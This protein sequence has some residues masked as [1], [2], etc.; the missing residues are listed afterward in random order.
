[1]R[2]IKGK[3]EGINTFLLS[4]FTFRIILAAMPLSLLDSSVISK[5]NKMKISRQLN[6]TKRLGMTGSLLP[7]WFLF[8]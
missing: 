7:M 2:E 5:G 3:I 8:Y 4:H 6:C 1:M